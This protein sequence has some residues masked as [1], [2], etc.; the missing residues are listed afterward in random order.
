MTGIAVIGAGAFGTALAIA[1]ASAGKEVVLLGRDSGKMERYQGA[2]RNVDYLPDNLFPETL[3]ATADPAAIPPGSVLVLAVPAQQVRGAL[4]EYTALLPDAPL[5]LAAKGLERETGELLTSVA[6]EFRFPSRLAVLSGPG[7]ADEIA[8]GLPTALTLAAGDDLVT[9]LQT[10]LST[11]ALRLYRTTDLIGVQ[12]G[13][14]LK[15]VVAIACG[16]ASGARLGESARAALMTRGFAEIVRL[17]R[18]M[19][20]RGET[21]TGLSGLGDLSLTCGSA[22]SR[23]FERGLAIGQGDMRTTGKTTEGVATAEAVL[24]LGQRYRIDLPVAA[25]TAEVL[26]GR[27]DVRG[28]MDRLLA[29][30]LKSEA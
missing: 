26:A 21:F 7:F 24:V 25:T 10:A 1:W 17:G 19:G 14:A 6:A 12:L 13:G 18:A 15:N 23:N 8:A 20:G 28:S 2:R 3:L 9:D 30:P 27:L 22:K 16:I 29:R 11:P 5:I 4:T